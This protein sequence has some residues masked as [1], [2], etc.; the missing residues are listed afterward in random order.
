MKEEWKSIIETNGKYEI[1]NFGNLR[2]AD[3]YARV[4]GNGKRF[5]KG[6]PIRPIKCSNGYL[7]LQASMGKRRKCLLVHRLVALYFIPNPNGYTEVNHKDEN[8][9][10]NHVDNLE[11]CTP[12]YN[13]NYGT[14]NKR[15]MEK[16][17]KRA[18]NQLTLDGELIQTFS[19]IKDAERKTGINSSQI[20]RVCKNRNLTAGGYKWEYAE[21]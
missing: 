18:I 21:V 9:L 8:P 5:V 13:C 20:I 19:M 12:K 2:S 6:K 16:V 3:R 15:C 7:E 1:S 4:C 14:R 11:W 17:I 10:N